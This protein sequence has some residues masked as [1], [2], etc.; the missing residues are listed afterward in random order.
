MKSKSRKSLLLI[1][2]CGVAQSPNLNGMET[3]LISQRACRY[4]AWLSNWRNRVSKFTVSKK[5][6]NL[7]LI[8]AFPCRHYCLPEAS[9][10]YVLLSMSDLL[11]TFALKPKSVQL[12]KRLM[13]KQLL[14]VKCARNMQNRRFNMTRSFKPSC[15][16]LVQ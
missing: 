14:I 8:Y 16:S 11:K 2:R 6:I 9:I 13:P 7:F 3:G 4:V 15:G 10:N 12:S 1:G 5:V